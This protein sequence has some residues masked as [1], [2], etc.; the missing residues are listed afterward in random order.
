MASTIKVFD[1]LGN[2]Y[3]TLNPLMTEHGLRLYVERRSATGGE[4]VAI[5]DREQLAE[6]TTGPYHGF[7]ISSVPYVPDE[8]HGFYGPA[9][10]HHVIAGH[11]GRIRGRELEMLVLRVVSKEPDRAIRSFQDALSKMLRTR[12]DYGSGIESDTGSRYPRIFYNK[13]TIRNKDLRFELDTSGYAL[14]IANV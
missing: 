14:R 12:A 1:S 6:A 2:V 8:P 9:L 13:D 10:E 3:D 4:M 11:G 7:Y 5:A